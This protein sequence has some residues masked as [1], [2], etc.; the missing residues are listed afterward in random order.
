MGKV[1]GLQTIG[2][3]SLAFAQEFLERS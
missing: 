2:D 3:L 1:Q